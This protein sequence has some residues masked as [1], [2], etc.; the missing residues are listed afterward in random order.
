MAGTTGTGAAQPSPTNILSLIKGEFAAFKEALKMKMQGSITAALQPI[1]K[2]LEALS[3]TVSQ[4]LQKA[5]KALDLSE[6]AM[7]EIKSLH[8]GEDALY[9]RLVTLDHAQRQNN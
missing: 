2:Q 6:T 3:L 7:S 1:S 9:D 4:A 5:C 8:M